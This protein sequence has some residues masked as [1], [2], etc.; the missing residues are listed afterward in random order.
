MGY[1]SKIIYGFSNIHYSIDG[2]NI[3]PLLGGIDITVEFEDKYVTARKNGIESIKVSGSLDGQGSLNVLGL[4]MEEMKD[5]LGY[6]GVLGEMYM[7]NSFDSKYITLLFER[8]KANG[9]KLLN[10]LY[11]CKF[12]VTGL[13]AQTIQEGVEQEN[14]EL[15]FKCV[16][17]DSRYNLH[18]F[19]LDTEEILNKDKVDNFFKVIQLPEGVKNK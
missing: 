9:S 5:I 12:D 7:D 18:C 16:S 19:V 3:K 6:K 8:Q 15:K 13:S 1:E 17:D 10:V 2:I 11:K 14:I 4:T